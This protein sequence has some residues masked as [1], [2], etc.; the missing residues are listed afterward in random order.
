[1]ALSFTKL[2]REAVFIVRTETCEERGEQLCFRVAG[3]C[4][5]PAQSLLAISSSECSM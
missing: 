4:A 2:F 3:A 1:M 5:L